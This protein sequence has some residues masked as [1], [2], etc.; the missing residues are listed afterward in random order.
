VSGGQLP[1][2][3]ADGKELF[4]IAL[5][6]RLMETEIG[7]NGSEME[8]GAT[9]PLFGPLLTGNGYQYDVSANGQ[10]FFAIMPNEQVVPA[11]LTL[12]RNWTV[13]L[14]KK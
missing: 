8:I 7:V 4:Y 6:S 10:R 14:K 5:D 3:R 12:V 13:A 1:R 2:W 9:R 11:P